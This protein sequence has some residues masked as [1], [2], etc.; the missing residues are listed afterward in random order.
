MIYMHAES[1]RIGL[2]HAH[3]HALSVTANWTRRKIVIHELGATAIW[4]RFKKFMLRCSV[5]VI[6]DSISVTCEKYG[7]VY[8]WGGVQVGVT[9]IYSMNCEW[10]VER[11]CRTKN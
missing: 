4:M 8:G 9:V 10:W 1:G 2:I 5:H 7:V 3:H 6:S 11:L